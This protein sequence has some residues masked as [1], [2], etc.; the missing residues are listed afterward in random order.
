MHLIV[1]Q[2][3]DLPPLI[4][5][6]MFKFILQLLALVF[7]ISMIDK[8]Y[9]RWKFSKDNRMSKQEIK[10]EYRQ[11]NG[12][13]KI[14]AKIKQLQQQL[15]KKTTSLK[16]V[17]TADVVI[18][19]PTHLAVVLKY[20][21]GLMPAPKVVCKAQGELVKNIK[22]LAKRHQI[23][24]IENKKFARALFATVD[25]NQW[26]SREHFPLAA[27]IFREIYRQKDIT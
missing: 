18:T 20:D 8:G 22:L 27:M 2:P 12:D 7:A 11:R 19:N 3:A 1:T 9:T 17:K 25:L 15:R 21:R 26:I 6:L 10:D 23:P 16:H 4:I 5:P 24:I 14:K 13:P